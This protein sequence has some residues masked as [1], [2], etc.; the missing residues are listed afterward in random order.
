M[1]D[2]TNM[3][4]VE[5]ASKTHGAIRCRC[6]QCGVYGPLDSICSFAKF[7]G[8]RQHKEEWF[9]RS[10]QKPWPPRPLEVNACAAQNS[11][12]PAPKHAKS[13]KYA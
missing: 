1:N 4:G 9:C 5:R 10:C 13:A 12:S 3:E 7:S 8:Y 2:A 6:G 11:P